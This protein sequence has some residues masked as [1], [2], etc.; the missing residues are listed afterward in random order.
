MLFAVAKRK[1]WNS[2]V[3]LTCLMPRTTCS[4]LLAAAQQN[5]CLSLTLQSQ[6]L[7]SP[8][9]NGNLCYNCGKL[10]FHLFSAFSPRGLLISSQGSI[11]WFFCFQQCLHFANCNMLAVT[12][13]HSKSKHRKIKVGC[14]RN[15]ALLCSK[16]HISMAPGISGRQCLAAQCCQ[17]GETCVVPMHL[18]CWVEVLDKDFVLIYQVHFPVLPSKSDCN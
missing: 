11:S 18:L 7:M 1:Y 9:S 13:N 16:S 3:L 8:S 17:H 15:S 14:T 10:H 4:S 6:N 12:P 5:G 2:H